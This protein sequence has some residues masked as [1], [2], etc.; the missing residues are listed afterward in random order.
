MADTIHLTFGIKSYFYLANESHYPFCDERGMMWQS[1]TQFLVSKMFGKDE[2]RVIF[3][4]GSNISALTR[5]CTPKISFSP[6]QGKWEKW[7][8]FVPGKK[9]KI[10]KEWRSL[11]YRNG[12]LQK[13]INFKFKQ[14]KNL[15][16]KLI[17]SGNANLRYDLSSVK[18]FE[19]SWV[20]PSTIRFLDH[21]R[22]TYRESTSIHGYKIPTRIEDT[23]RR[24]TSLRKV[25]DSNQILTVDDD[26]I[27][28]VI[29]VINL[30]VRIAP[31]EGQN[32][33]FEGMEQDAVLNIIKYNPV[34]SPEL[35]GIEVCFGYIN[36]AKRCILES[37]DGI[38]LYDDLPNFCTLF[39]FTKI[40]LDR[41]DPDLTVKTRDNMAFYISLFA[42]WFHE[43]CPG[44]QF[45]HIQNRLRNIRGIPLTFSPIKQR[46]YRSNALFDP[47]ITSKTQD[48]FTNPIEESFYDD[49]DPSLRLSYIDD[50]GNPTTY[51][52]YYS[53]YTVVGDDDDSDSKGT[54]RRKKKRRKGKTKEYFTFVGESIDPTKNSIYRQPPPTSSTTT[55]IQ[56]VQTTAESSVP[57]QSPV[58]TILRTNLPEGSD[59]DNELIHAAVNAGINV[60]IPPRETSR[61]QTQ[62]PST[63]EDHTETPVKPMRTLDIPTSS[64]S[65]ETAATSSTSQRPSK[66]NTSEEVYLPDT[67]STHDTSGEDLGVVEGVGASVPS[68]SVTS[69]STSGSWRDIEDDTVP[70]VGLPDVV[71]GVSVPVATS[72]PSTSETAASVEGIS[73][74]IGTE[75]EVGMS[76][77]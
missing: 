18:I 48:S 24:V 21:I 52:D 46:E 76:E 22:K 54:H 58:P 12:E 23:P 19:K 38:R 3:G 9:S 65:T 28:T 77:E 37:I 10:R 14:N 43:L 73:E 31:H 13:A 69:A 25:K 75:T 41:C 61:A 47:H 33:L 64:T 5:V 49:F 72:V 60:K 29:S 68:A 56:S 7:Y 34:K 20:I 1:V 30:V 59:L 74:T 16:K 15:F 51:E 66:N 53:S 45:M 63:Y 4:I 2:E 42:K 27:E 35:K 39:E 26:Y 57:I 36:Y 67:Q 50:N 17:S 11:S 32:R 40:Y 44:T 55:S 6:S 70:P 71:E 62:K 8:S